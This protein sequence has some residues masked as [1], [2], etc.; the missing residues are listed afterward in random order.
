MS[1]NRIIKDCSIGQ[2]QAYTPYPGDNIAVNLSFYASMRHAKSRT[3]YVSQTLNMTAADA[4][5]LAR[6]LIE[7]ADHADKVRIVPEQ[8]AA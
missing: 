6:V 8:E 7:A 1:D 5:D 3:A 2:V 4:R